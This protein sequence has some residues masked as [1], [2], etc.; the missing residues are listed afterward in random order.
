MVI[1]MTRLV[2]GI[3]INDAGYVVRPIINN[4]EVWC[5][6]YKAWKGMLD[7]CYNKKWQLINNTYSSCLVDE[8]WHRFSEFRRWMES[9]DWKGKELDKDILVKGNKVYSP[10]TCAFVDG[11]TNTF[12]VDCLS[13][14]GSLPVG[15]SKVIS[16][17][18]FVAYCRNFLTK[19]NENL[20]LF[21][22]ENAAH[23]A[24]KKRKHQ[25][26]CQL[27]ELQT[28]QRIADA[29]RVRYL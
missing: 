21:T 8:R 2:Y 16:N 4:K 7:R 29:L 10:E 20:G 18:L 12:V 17:G 5:P 1:V 6:F 14:R 13:A 11:A 3:G 22:C 9:Q 23:Q 26:A 28:D 19:K 15:V 24:W 27:A 25:L